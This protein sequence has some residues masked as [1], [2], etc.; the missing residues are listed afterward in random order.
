MSASDAPAAPSALRV[1][2][3]TV[4]HTPQDARILHRQ[5]AALRAR[6]H[7]VTYL[8]PFTAYGAARPEGVTCYDV[9]RSRGLHRIGP[10][11]AAGWL[12][13]RLAG[14]H[15]VVLAHDP[16]LLP[17]LLVLRARRPGLPVVWDVHED[18]AAQLDLVPSLPRRLKPPAAAMIRAVERAAERWLHLL[19]AEHS[20]QERF[21]RPHPVVPNSVRVPAVMPAAPVEDRVIYVGGITRARGVEEL[22]DLARRLA[23]D[24][25]VELIGPAAPELDERLR[26]E[27]A[28]TNVRYRGFIPNG[29]AL[30]RLPGALAGL[31]LL[32]DQPNYAH[33]QPTKVMEYM[34]HGLP[35]VTTANPASRELVERY[36]V[37][38]VIGFGDMAT[39]AEHIRVLR[40]DRALR[41]EMGARGWRAAR[42]HHDWSS[43]GERFVDQL[44]AW[45][46]SPRPR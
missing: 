29:E 12:A 16:E 26:R 36:D 24:V 27:T 13:L 15:D 42:A 25:A 10:V 32:H 21:T 2:V 22:L 30:A 39:A 17:V 19:L 38:R 8:A 5:V 31:S 14:D 3:V 34:A 33:S 40:D 6:G 20:Y 46:R 28:G 9:P 4:T 45:C 35:T 7:R 1:L 44:E 37:G 23:P 43:D 18:V 41:A 11:L